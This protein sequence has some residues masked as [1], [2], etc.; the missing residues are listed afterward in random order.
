MMIAT[1]M[2]AALMVTPMAHSAPDYD[3]PR[4]YEKY[5]QCVSHRESRHT[6]TAVN[7]TG[8]YRGLYQMDH[9]LA[10]GATHWIMG[11]LS[12]WHPKPKAYAA[13]LRATPVNKWPAS[14]QTAAFV[15]TLS[16]HGAR[17]KWSGAD[18]WYYPNSRCNS[19]VGAR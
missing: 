17:D 12:T 13:W 9:A 10:S 16:G 4:V 2:T 14:V 3:V 1:M 8:K 18:H 15:V 7:P 19:L 5:E 6:P 11:W